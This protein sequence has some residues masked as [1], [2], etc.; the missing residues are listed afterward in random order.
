MSVDAGLA[1]QCPRCGGRL[2]PSV[3]GELCPRCLLGLALGRD[4]TSPESVVAPT[5]DG[6]LP[7][8]IAV[9]PYVLIEE[10]ARGGVGIVYRACHSELG[11]EVALKMLLPARLLAPEAFAR[12]RREARTMA[13]LDHPGILPIYEVGEDGGLPYFTMKLA[14]GGSLAQRIADYRERWREIAGLVA[15]IAEA[16]AAA[17]AQ[18]IV[19]RDLKPANVL[20][21]VD[22]TP[23]VSD[24]G[25]A[26]SLDADSSLTAPEAALGTPRYMAPEAATGAR[27]A[28]MPATDVYSIGAI[29]HELLCG[30]PQW[31]GLST[32]QVLERLARD[33][34]DLPRRID[35]AVP[36][37]LERICLWARAR[38]PEA[39]PSAHTLAQALR[40]YQRGRA[41]RLP[42]VGGVGAHSRLVT[43]VV[44]LVVGGSVAWWWSHH[45]KPPATPTARSAPTA[46]VVSGD[47]TRRV[48]V[49]APSRSDGPNAD[50]HALAAR[51]AAD[52]RSR[53]AGAG[54]GDIEVHAPS[55]AGRSSN[56][57][58]SLSPFERGLARSAL[59][60]LEVYAISGRVRIDLV[61][62]LRRERLR[63]EATS[64]EV[65]E[66]TVQRLAQRLV[67][68]E[69]AQRTPAPSDE[70]L[71][72][73]VSGMRE[74]ERN[75]E[76]ASQRAVRAFDRAIEL[77]PRSALAHAWLALTYA[78][79][80]MQFRR[81][82][83]WLD[84]AAYEAETALQ[85]DPELAAGHEALGFALYRKGWQT[86][87]LEAFERAQ[88][89]GSIASDD[90]LALLY[91]ATGRF[92]EALGTY[93]RS[94]D[95]RRPGLMDPYFPAAVLYTIGDAELG[96]AFM[97]AMLP[98][99]SLPQRR[100]FIEAVIAYYRHDCTTALAEIANVPD[101]SVGWY[102]YTTELRRHCAAL[103]RDWAAAVRVNQLDPATRPTK[104]DRRYAQNAVLYHLLGQREESRLMADAVI[105]AAAADHDAGADYYGPPLYQAA[106][107]RMQGRTEEAYRLLDV[108]IARGFTINARNTATPELLPFAG[109]PRYAELQAGFEARF[110][111]MRRRCRDLVATAGGLDALV[112][113]YAPTL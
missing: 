107:F 62:H 57:A 5:P 17:H 31:D 66:A 96:E 52:L 13:R 76:H 97:R 83:H 60:T 87:T 109:D 72:L 12:F 99:E 40:C 20:F 24:F 4:V 8:G 100:A 90:G 16:V 47:W 45:G 54:A 113:H 11:R 102:F 9:G 81:G 26:R 94:F 69:R 2:A 34:P 41:V 61:D 93:L 30:K 112:P 33:A 50:A 103:Q 88:A 79:R 46:P 7:L 10:L 38:T 21:D 108:A 65:D 75:N 35:P 67:E 101:T 82:M 44:L 37:E 68:W 84:S 36:T 14:N 89:R 80:H 48:A 91:Y 1:Q 53:L 98:R 59:R 25:L 85:L 105:Q 56:D 58:A 23:M 55:D 15:G 74:F 27:N 110:R 64:Y 28:L 49:L 86:R 19:H 43:A 51:L 92:D 104:S 73:I 63:I 95:P 22:D 78:H 39:R 71:A 77:A 106:M 18:G 42:R 6:R 70:V 29:L 32:A 3:E 111:G